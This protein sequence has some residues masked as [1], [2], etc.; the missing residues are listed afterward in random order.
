MKDIIVDFELKNP[1]LMM[2]KVIEEY[3]ECMEKIPTEKA[4]EYFEL[5][6]KKVPPKLIRGVMFAGLLYGLNHP[7]EIVILKKIKE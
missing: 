2:G 4:K 7:D 5:W 6:D 3:C 1:H